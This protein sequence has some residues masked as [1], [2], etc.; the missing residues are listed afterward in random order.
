MYDNIGKMSNYA[1]ISIVSYISFSVIFFFILGHVAKSKPNNILY[2]VVFVLFTF[3]IQLGLNMW[4][5]T[6]SNICGTTDSNYAF[7][8]TVIPWFFILTLFIL[9]LNI[10]P[11]WLR[12]FS[13]TLGLWYVDY[14]MLKTI[15]SELF[16]NEKRKEISK[17][18]IEAARSF[19]GPKTVSSGTRVADGLK[20]ISNRINPGQ[21]GGSSSISQT[22]L[23]SPIPPGLIGTV[24]GG[25]KAGA[26]RGMAGA[27]RAAASASKQLTKLGTEQK[28]EDIISHTPI[29]LLRLIDSVYSNPIPL[30][31]ELDINDAIIIDNITEYN[32]YI[33]N[34]NNNKI[35]INKYKNKDISN[36]LIDIDND[37]FNK[38]KF[39]D[40]ESLNRITPTYIEITNQ[41]IINDLYD[42]IRLKDTVG[43]FF[44]LLMVG[45]TASLISINSLLTSKC[46]DKNNYNNIYN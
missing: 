18:T 13:N 17:Q 44:W 23:A 1:S 8:H 25:V 43:Y 15:I 41:N 21:T 33:K 9:L 26:V 29:V 32:N 36:N 37:F 7:Y 42:A 40:W 38:Y 34:N 2:L 3:F 19:D 5:S 24:T 20:S 14:F 11:G 27:S 30:I 46:K 39:Y 16:T 6:D 45:S 35:F 31:N 28:T 10:F 4:I 22:N 12:V